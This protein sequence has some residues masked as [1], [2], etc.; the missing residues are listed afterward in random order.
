MLDLGFGA[1][2]DAW[3]VAITDRWLWAHHAYYPSRL[4]GYPVHELVSALLIPGGW[5]ATNSATMVVSLVGVFLFAA[6]VKRRAPGVQGLLT[7]TFAFTPLLWI[8]STVTMDYMWALTFLLASYLLLLQRRFVPAG[9]ALGVAAGCRLTIIAFLGPFLLILLHDR[10]VRA[11]VRLT[12]ASLLSAAVV[13]TPVWWRY[14]LRMFD[15]ADWRPT[16]GE[17]ART[18]GVEAGSLLTFGSLVLILLLSLPQIR[19]VPALIRRDGHLAGWL[20]AVLLIFAVFMRLPL[21]EA[22]LI[23][24]VP[25]AFLAMA[26]ILRRPLLYAACALIVAG[27]FVDVYTA[28]Q[29]GWTSPTALLQL[30]PEKG[31]VLVDRELRVQRMQVVREARRYPLPPNSALTMG[32]YYPIL[33]ELFHDEL[34]LHFREPFDPRI[35]GPLTDIT[36]AV[37]Q[38]NR[39]YVWLLNEMQVR[40]YQ[41]QGYTTW[42]MDYDSVHHL[43]VEQTLEPWRNR[44]GPR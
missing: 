34:D 21:E 15:F 24:A 7:L 22:Y 38:D 19:R 32:Y 1:D 28:S 37:D 12:A 27:G 3:R 17:V 4:P 6:I 36:A 42:T 43:T 9:I 20:A 25:F 11:A 14:G 2:A 44:F 18:L 16:W 5:L 10:E 35:I 31:R 26:R 30:R 40:R 39:T 13:F 8:N 33:A 29:A 23:P 41:K